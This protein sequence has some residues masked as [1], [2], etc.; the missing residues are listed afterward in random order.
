MPSAEEGAAVFRNAARNWSPWTRS[1]T[2]SP[3]AAAHSPAATL[4]AWPTT[5]TASRLPRAQTRSTQKPVSALW[6]ATRSTR[7]ARRS[8]GAGAGA[9]GGP[10]E[11]AN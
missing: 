9:A 8:R 5:V 6:K 7:P 1:L 2:Q 11:P 10:V 3:E 4:A